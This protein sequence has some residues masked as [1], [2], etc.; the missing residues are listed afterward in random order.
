MGTYTYQQTV[1]CPDREIKCP[2]VLTECMHFLGTELVVERV[3]C[4][5]DNQIGGGSLYTY[6]VSDPDYYRKMCC[7]EPSYTLPQCPTR[8]TTYK[9]ELPIEYGEAYWRELY[10]D[11]ARFVPVPPPGGICGE[12]IIKQQIASNNCC[13]GVPDLVWDTSVSPEVMAPNSAVVIGVTGG[14]KYPYR[15]EVDGHGFQFQNGSRSIETTGNQVRLSALVTACGTAVVTVT[16]GCTSCVGDIR[17]TA[18][19]WDLLGRFVP[20]A[21]FDYRGHGFIE[22]SVN[23][24]TYKLSGQGEMRGGY[25]LGH[26]PGAVGQESWWYTTWGAGGQ[27]ISC[28]DPA[29]ITMQDPYLGVFKIPILVGSPASDTDSSFPCYPGSYWRPQWLNSD[30]G[31]YVWSC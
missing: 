21:V 25:Y 22:Q 24:Y 13:D 29:G 15:W 23:G 11:N 7:Q 20:S 9:G 8:R 4:S 2:G 16:D 26:T 1:P 30:L 19:K 12:W 31:I 28:F 3:D 10:G 6:K 14:G 5:D 18:G 17:C 27:W